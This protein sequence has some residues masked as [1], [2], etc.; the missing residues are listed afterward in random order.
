MTDDAPNNHRALAVTQGF[1][2]P[3]AE[4]FDGNTVDRRLETV[5]TEVMTS[6]NFSDTH[7]ITRETVYGGPCDHCDGEAVA[8]FTINFTDGGSVGGYLCRHHVN[9]YEAAYGLP[10]STERRVAA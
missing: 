3:S 8:F 2:K 6:T 5:F 4:G 9:Q 1:G 10:L 7:S